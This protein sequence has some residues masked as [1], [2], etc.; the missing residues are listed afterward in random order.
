MYATQQHS[1][2]ATQQH[3]DTVLRI[4][5]ADDD[6]DFITLLSRTIAK[7][8]NFKLVG[9]AYNGQELLLNIQ[10]QYPHLVL[11]DIQMP[12][13]DG[14]EATKLIRELYPTTNILSLSSYNEPEKI[15]AI[16]Q[17]GAN[18]YIYKGGITN[19]LNL[20]IDC[21]LSGNEYVSQCANIKRKVKYINPNIFED[22]EEIDLEIMRIIANGYTAKEIGKIIFKSDKTVEAHKSI[23]MS[24]YS[25]SNTAEFVKFIVE[26]LF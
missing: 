23:L 1:N 5:L 20:A 12:V 19:E 10:Q 22:V 15:S 14:I 3:K 24:R 11:V 8:K 26:N 17:A 13:I 21:I 2:T 25:V 9:K 16:M 4:S 6:V 18:G 7:Q